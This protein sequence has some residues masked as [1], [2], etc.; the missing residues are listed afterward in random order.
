MIAEK[1][2][3]THEKLFDELTDKAR[4]AFA[5][6][7]AYLRHQR[8]MRKP[9]AAEV[10]DALT[11]FPKA[12]YQLLVVRQ[13]ISFYTGVRNLLNEQLQQIVFCRKLADRAATALAAHQILAAPADARR[14]L[15]PGC[16]TIRDAVE[17]FLAN[18]ADEDWTGLHSQIQGRIGQEFGGLLNLCMNSPDAAGVL[19][20]VM[21]EEGKA[22]FGERLGDAHVGEMLFAKFPAPGQADRVL[23]KAFHDAAPELVRGGPG[24]KVELCV[25]GVPPGDDGEPVRALARRAL[26]PT[27]LTLAPCADE[28]VLYREYPLVPLNALPHL[29]PVGTTAYNLAPDLAHTRTDIPKWFDVDAD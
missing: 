29:G 2:L 7:G 14:L 5:V 22:F 21:E 23:A 16:E 1:T 28:I 17:R 9:S 4:S 15:P 11:A 19:G 3:I 27:D 24:A 20:R 6:L 25:I 18:L 8:G 13:L 10:A 26:P 12:R